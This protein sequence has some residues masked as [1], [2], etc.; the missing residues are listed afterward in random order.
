M[1]VKLDIELKN[2]SFKN[3]YTGTHRKKNEK[4]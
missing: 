2:V 1:A 3:K 4:I